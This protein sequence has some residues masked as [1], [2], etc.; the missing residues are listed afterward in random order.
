MKKKVL[1]TATVDSHILHFHIPYLKMFKENGYE[2]H[3]ATNGNEDIQYCDKKHFISFERSPFKIG[4]LKAI[5]Q[6]KKII[7]NEKFDIIHCHT[8]MG[9]VVTRL[10]ARSARKNRTRLI[11]TAHGF[12]FYQGAP[13]LNWLLFYPIE[14][15]LSYITDDLIT[16]NNEDYELAKKKFHAKHTHYIPGV[17]V[18]PQKFDFTMT[19]DE[20]HN[21][22][23]E[24]SIKDNDMILIYVAELIKRKNQSMAIYAVKELVKENKNIKLLLVGKDSYHGKYQ[25]LVNELGI[26][27]N[28]IFT[29]YRKDI[30]K[31]MKISD[32]A[33]STALQEGLPV[34]LMEAGLCGLPIVATNCRGNRDVLNYDKKENLVE[35]NDVVDMTKK[36]KKVISGQYTVLNMDKYKLENIVKEMKFIYNCF[37]DTNSKERVAIITSGF[38]PVPATKG[39][40]AENLI[41]T[42]ISQNEIYHK[43]HPIIFST[44]DKEGLEASEKYNNSDFIFIKPNK[45][46]IFIDKF[47]YFIID[48]ILKRPNSRK[49]RY[50]F[51]RFDFFNKCSI[52][53]KKNKYDKVLLENHTVMY[54][55]L[56]WRKNY[57]KYD[58]NYYYHCH[59]EVPSLYGMNDIIQKTKRFIS[60]SNF[61]NDYLQKKWSIPKEKTSVVFNCCSSDIYRKATDKEKE[62]L[63]LKYNIVE[64]KIILYVGRVDKDKGTLELIKACNQIEN[65][66]FKL[67]IVGAPIFATGITTDYEELVKQ[68]VAK[69]KDKYIMT[70]YVN[71]ADLY[72]YY[73]IADVVAIPSQV[74]DSAPLVLIES[75]SSGK[76]IVATDCGGIPEYVNDKCACL[77]KRDLNYIH[78][79][80]VALENIL[81]HDVVK[82]EMEQESLNRSKLYNEN[83]YYCDFISQLLK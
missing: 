54:L 45:L 74:E 15:I 12:H 77:I 19:A 27:E 42:L 11:Y 41:D 25:Q 3:V 37:D 33:I 70:G 71:H 80:A 55:S 83:K 61:R 81:Q 6:L 50:I 47:N 52:L 28:V 40:A 69:N 59:N 30:P 56:K 21:I 39:G 65:T 43:I 10:A 38:L 24:F 2:V 58:N 13:I 46:A 48:K 82:N 44:Y 14:K 66:A 64:E 4:N 23:S 32:I 9:S 31:L 78:N 26:N 5:L 7:D 51:Q 53:L 76:P 18:D 68:E 63:K 75:L 79:F 57:L 60:V 35:I 20:R 16:I 49:F 67:I 73:S 36:L 34:N 62:T 17:G 1:F 8:P 29:G 22:R 72:Q